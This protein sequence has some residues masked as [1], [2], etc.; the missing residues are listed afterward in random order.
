M[1][2]FG[3]LAGSSI[4]VVDILVALG[5]AACLAQA[6][7]NTDVV[8]MNNGDKFVG[9]IK[10]LEEGILYFGAGYT[11]EDVQ[12]DWSKVVRV[13][14]TDVFTVILANGT[15]DTGSIHK[16]QEPDATT[17]GFSIISGGGTTTAR[18]AEVVR[19]SQT[20]QNFWNQLAGALNFGFSFTGGTSATQLNYSGNVAYR[21]ERWGAK[22]DGSSV[23]NR[24]EGA[25]D[26]GRNTLTLSFH[27][28]RGQRWFVAGITNILTSQQQNL[29]LRSTF[30]TGIGV[31]LV[32]RSR[33]ILQVLG[34]ALFFSE[35]YSPD[36]GSES[37]RGADS[38]FLLQFSTNRFT[39]F[40]F[41]M[42][43]GIFPSLTEL[44]RVRLS[45]DSSLKREIARN[46][47]VSFTV[48]ENYDSQPPVNAPKNDFGT[49]MTLGWSF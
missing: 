2:G 41:E 35:K 16:S 36:S 48:Y 32:Q 38:Q 5:F 49:S 1:A 37:G 17:K 6:R 40:Q 15:R 19:I 10:R 8:I 29:D 24:Q 45:I 42:D 3:V 21:A 34:G 33:T 28:Y 7:S 11:A 31:D 20:E 26:S 23:L 22:L 14:T 30:G 39:K 43:A 46:L 25:E 4:C 44:G 13:D 12:L 27:R 47:N 18:N 9:E